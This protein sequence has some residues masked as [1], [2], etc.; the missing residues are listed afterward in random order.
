MERA[1]RDLEPYADL[2]DQVGP[3]TFVF[4][5]NIILLKLK[6]QEPLHCKLQNDAYIAGNDFALGAV[7]TLF[8]WCRENQQ[9]T[10][11]Q[12]CKQPQ[13]NQTTS[14]DKIS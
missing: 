5:T 10:R 1:M 11:T 2:P 4:M 13:P 12:R 9:I 8:L 6:D 3:R 7:T 14:N